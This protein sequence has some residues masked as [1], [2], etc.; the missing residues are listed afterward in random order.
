MFPK[1]L[2]MGQKLETV[3][4]MPEKT[5]A[6]RK[7]AAPIQKRAKET[8][9]QLLKASLEIIDT[10]GIEALNS[11]AV[12]EAI[13]GTPPTFYRYFS[14]KH[15]VLEVLGNRLMNVQSELVLAEIGTVYSDQGDA[16]DSIYRILAKTLELTKNIQGSYALLMSLRA[17]P[18]LRQIR[19]DSH[20]KLTE[21]GAGAICA[22]NP[23]A[24]KEEVR[25]QVR[26]AM[27]IGYT[28]IELLYETDF[29]NT[30]KVL[31]YTT[32]SILKIFEPFIG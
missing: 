24:D 13:G 7:Q 10:K 30:E 2:L 17:I 18:N 26:L 29:K 20:E 9:E 4:D 27:E 11:N 32:R 19:T 3:S 12:V 22:N 16:Y 6:K 8:Y 23:G 5:R 31:D 15:E 28:A 25:V 14:D 21:I 1:L